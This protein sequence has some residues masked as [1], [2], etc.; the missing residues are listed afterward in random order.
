MQMF[1]SLKTNV[2]KSLKPP[3][4]IYESKLIWLQTS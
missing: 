3:F 4:N 2:T 1:I